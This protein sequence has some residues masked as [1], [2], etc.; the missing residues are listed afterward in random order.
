MGVGR[1]ARCVYGL[2][3][4]EIAASIVC[5]PYRIPHTGW[6]DRIGSLVITLIVIKL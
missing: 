3:A 2:I 5:Y 6:P 4:V 1:H